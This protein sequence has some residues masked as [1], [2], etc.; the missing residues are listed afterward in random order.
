MYCSIWKIDHHRVL[1]HTN[2]IIT[3][4][5]MNMKKSRN[6]ILVNV[7]IFDIALE[8]TSSQRERGIRNECHIS[9]LD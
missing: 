5:S 6:H 9:F 1:T 2:R 8:R 7:E 3:V 4:L